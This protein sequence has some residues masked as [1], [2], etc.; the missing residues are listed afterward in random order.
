MLGR[1]KGLEL[2][3]FPWWTHVAWT[4]E[5][6]R[7]RAASGAKKFVR[8]ASLS[9]AVGATGLIE[10]LEAADRALNSIAEYAGITVVE[11]TWGLY[12]GQP[13]RRVR[14]YEG[15]RLASEFVPNGYYLVAEVA[16]VGPL[17]EVETGSEPWLQICKRIN[18]FYEDTSIPGPKMS[19]ID[20]NQVGFHQVQ[21][22][23]GLAS[24]GATIL[25]IDP[26]FNPSSWSYRETRPK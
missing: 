13:P 9:H 17:V 5:Q 20:V 15:W 11:H 8:R 4:T 6:I 23:D 14:K 19:N 7:A 12:K 18:T 22:A 21:T 26:I 24:L 3:I 1:N 25:D 10:A 2:P 16:N